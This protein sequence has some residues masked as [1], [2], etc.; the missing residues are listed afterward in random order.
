[1]ASKGIMQRLDYYIGFFV[2]RRKNQLEEISLVQWSTVKAPKGHRGLG[3]QDPTL[4]NLEMGAKL[5]WNMVSRKSSQ[6]KISNWL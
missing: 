2:V 1:M 4:M 3:I 6:G 5:T